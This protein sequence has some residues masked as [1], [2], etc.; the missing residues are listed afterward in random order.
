MKQ[1]KNKKHKKVY[2]A[3]VESDP[4]VLRQLDKE[5]QHARNINEDLVKERKPFDYRDLDAERFIYNY[6]FRGKR[7]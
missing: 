3:P 2:V 7:L 4:S 6:L 1:N 5:K